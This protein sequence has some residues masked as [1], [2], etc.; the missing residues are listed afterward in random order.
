MN[1]AR[2]AFSLVR[3]VPGA[4]GLLL[5]ASCACPPLVESYETP[6]DALALWQ[7][8]LCRDDVQGEYECLAASFQRAM[9]GYATYHVAR[10]ALLEEDP[11]A[12]WVFERADLDDAIIE[13]GYGPDADTAWIVLGRGNGRL[14]VMFEREP[15]VTVRWAD[16]SSQTRRQKLP[17]DRLFDW[18]KDTPWLGLERPPIPKD[19]LHELRAVLMEPRWKISD[20]AGLA[21]G[22][23][24]NSPQVIP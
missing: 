2:T 13:T 15:Y 4:L 16:G 18:R 20:L 24:G 12:A 8:R 10:T 1:H 9:Q 17:L 19:R 7:A 21:T 22:S 23:T 6:R 14:T 3:L 5:S 11:V